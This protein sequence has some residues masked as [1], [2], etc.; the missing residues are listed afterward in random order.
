MHKNKNRCIDS[1]RNRARFLFFQNE[2]QA[3]LSLRKGVYAV[4]EQKQKIKQT[5]TLQDRQKLHLNTVGCIHRFDE[6]A[7]VLSAQGCR[8]L[9][10]GRDLKIE[11][12][13][14]DSAEVVIT[15]TV[16]GISFSDGAQDKRRGLFR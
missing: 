15:G 8:I 2:R 16:D 9:V 3:E 5:L 7:V 4:E 14:K 10:E 13:N 1:Y 11:Q 12:L 6:E